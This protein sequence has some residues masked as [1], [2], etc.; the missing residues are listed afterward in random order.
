MALDSILDIPVD[1]E[2][3]AARIRAAWPQGPFGPS[4]DVRSI[5]PAEAERT[6]DDM[7]QRPYGPGESAGRVA[8]VGPESP[9]VIVAA[10]HGAMDGLGMVA[11]TALALGEPLRSASRGVDPEL[12]T[13]PARPAYLAR[14]L[15]EALVAPPARFAPHGGTGSDRDHL[16]RVELPAGAST[17]DLVAAAAR[18]LRSWNRDHGRAARRVM[19]AVGASRRPGDEGALSDA[20]AW[21]RFRV[22]DAD[23]DHIRALL[24]EGSP[25]PSGSPTMHRPMVRRVASTLA[26]RTGSSF[27]MSN[28]GRL[29][30]AGSIRTSFL[31]GCVHG[32]S[33]VAFGSV[34]VGDSMTITL[35]VRQRDFSREAATALLA[36]A[37]AHLPV[38]SPS[39]GPPAGPAPTGSPE[40]P[41]PPA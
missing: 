26:G 11:L 32:R 30:E 36:A 20:S 24:R 16:V 2:A 8:I 1:P 6:V 12:A 14:R 33:G 15:G 41:R 23:P 17:A 13:R 19:A 35:R 27:L 34:T 18:A 37:V 10:Y 22:R 9:R 4:P 38:K 31:Y 21:F 5:E 7:A 28:L 25:A 40:A 39:P 29:V 3:A